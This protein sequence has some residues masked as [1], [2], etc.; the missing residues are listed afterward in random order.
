VSERN[1]LVLIIGVII[2]FVVAVICTTI[3]SAHGA[4]FRDQGGQVEAYTH[5]TRER[6]IS[7]GNH[8]PRQKVYGLDFSQQKLRELLEMV[9]GWAAGP[10]DVVMVIESRVPIVALGDSVRLCR[11]PAEYTDG[12]GYSYLAWFRRAVPDTL[13]ATC[14]DT[15]LV[16]KEVP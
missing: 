6:A 4:T 3:Q 8:H 1:E 2:V 15:V 10:A 11:P 13:K 12:K 14:R 5:L 7:L 9:C 16:L